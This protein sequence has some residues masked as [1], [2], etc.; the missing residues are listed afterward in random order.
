VVTILF[1]NLGG[2]PATLPRLRRLAGVYEVDIFLL[3]EAPDDLRPAIGA[4]NDA[5]VGRYR[6]LDL[7]RPK[8]RCLTWLPD[9]TFAP[10]FTWPYR[11]MTVW[12]LKSAKLNPPEL[13]LAVVHLPSKMGGESDASLAVN[14]SLVAADLAAYE[15]EHANHRNTVVVGDFNLN[16]FDPGMTLVRGF[17]GMMTRKLAR[18]KRERKQGGKAYPGFY[19]PMWGLFGDKTPGPAGTHYWR[20]SRTGNPW[21]ILDQVLLR[22]GVIDRLRGL[23]ILATDG[24]QSLCGTDGNPSKDHLSDH[25]PILFSLDV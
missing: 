13:S 16:P 1:W 20:K 12:E 10:R 19:N 9:A 7:A 18:G 21:S 15:D 25:L 22:K 17:Q 3:A 14:A 4:L 2:N 6:A 23:E 8:V 11:G 24:V 5:R